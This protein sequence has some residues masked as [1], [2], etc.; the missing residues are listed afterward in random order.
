MKNNE[1]NNYG[2]LDMLTLISFFAQMK[3]MNDDE[4]TSIKNNSIIKA[5]SNEIDK[6]HKENDDI[7]QGLKKIDNDEKT[8]LNK[9]DII[10]NILRGL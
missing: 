8:L 6:L 7:I 2:F 9:L 1:N 4:L 5:I 3:N 10:I